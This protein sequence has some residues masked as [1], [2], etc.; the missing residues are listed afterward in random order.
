VLSLGVLKAL[1][2]E[3]RLRAADNCCITEWIYII[4]QRANDVIQS[5]TAVVSS[6]IEVLMWC[7]VHIGTICPLHHI[8][9]SMRVS[10]RTSTSFS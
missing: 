5:V 6:T 8:D 3:S 7:S 9:T 10:T 1:T 4:S 2:K